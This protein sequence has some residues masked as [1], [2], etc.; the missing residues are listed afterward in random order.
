MRTWAVIYGIVFLTLGIL[1]FIPVWFVEGLLLSL[2][3]VNMW[4]NILYLATGALGL[5]ST[6]FRR[7]ATR[8]YF[9]VVGIV[10]TILAIGSFVFLDR[11]MLFLLANN[12]NNTWL[13]IVAGAIALILGFGYRRKNERT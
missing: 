1:G 12:N 6:L 4:L 7:E 10:Y 2:F 9:Q 13:S 11:K 3:E 8:L 5:F